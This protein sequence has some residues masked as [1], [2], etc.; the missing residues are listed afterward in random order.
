MSLALASGLAAQA[1]TPPQ[2]AARQVAI[3]QIRVVEGEG[4]VHAA[5][6]RATRGLV[7]EVTDE[8]GKPVGGVAVNFRL[9][10]EGPSGLF[11][12]GMKT[13]VVITTSDGRATLWG[14]QWNRTEGPFQIRIT[15]A[16][17]Q[18]RAGTI[19]SQYLSQAAAARQIGAS[20]TRPG[21]AP[22]TARTPLEVQ[23]HKCGALICFEA[24]FPRDSQ[25]MVNHGAQFLAFLTSD[26]W[27]GPTSE[28]LLH[29]Q[30]APLR[31]VENGGGRRN[32]GGPDDQ[33]KN[34]RT[35]GDGDDHNRPGAHH[36][37]ARYYGGETLDHANRSLSSSVRCGEL[38]RTAPPGKAA[39]RLSG[40]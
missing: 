40:R 37:R 35:A 23:A 12:N 15:A 20:G 8:T 36:R 29:S 25:A 39:N 26:A 9:P 13:E 4:A 7:V 16:K 18:A 27:A 6:S 17:D 21:V 14:M 22:G 38:R 30:T 5:G 33:F 34:K 1:T 28:V 19:V 24:I 31:A 11:A 3:L 2:A 32:G 10:D